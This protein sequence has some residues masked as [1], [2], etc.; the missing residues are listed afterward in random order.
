MDADERPAIR[1]LVSYPIQPWEPERWTDA[2][3]VSLEIA[4]ELQTKGYMVLVDPQ[5]ERDLAM[6]E[7]LIRSVERQRNKKWFER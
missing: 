1:A 2:A 7:R 3:V 6:Y 5:D 4:A